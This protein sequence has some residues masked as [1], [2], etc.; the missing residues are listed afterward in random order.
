LG[1]QVVSVRVL[2]AGRVQGVWYRKWTVGEARA[3][4]LDGWVRNRSNG[5]VEALFSGAFVMVR[6]MIAICRAG[7]P[8]SRVDTIEEHE[9]AALEAGSGF[10][11]RGS[12]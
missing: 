1:D 10:V 4:G 7:P 6:E 12:A 9:A 5:D 8:L 3:R 11:Q 2:I